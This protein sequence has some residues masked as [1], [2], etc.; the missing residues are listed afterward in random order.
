M[1][2]NVEPERCWCGLSKEMHDGRE[3]DREGN[4]HFFKEDLT[5]RTK[6]IDF[7]EIGPVI[8]PEP[9]FNTLTLHNL[10]QTVS[11]N[12][13]AESKERL[14]KEVREAMKSAAAFLELNIIN[15]A[16]GGSKKHSQGTVVQ[17]T[18]IMKSLRSLVDGA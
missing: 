3:V 8:H 7:D 12:S 13:K 5:E 6:R 9:D 16:R 11:V 18:K 2:G 17:A 15:P 10:E 1:N 14:G 4:M